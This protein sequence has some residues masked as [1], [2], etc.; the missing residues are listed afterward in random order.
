MTYYNG[1]LGAK[2]GI[3]KRCLTMKRCLYLLILFVIMLLPA[4]SLSRAQGGADGW[5]TIPL[6]LRAGPSTQAA[7]L[8]VLPSGTGIIIEAR[9]DDAAW[10]LAHTEDGAVRGW[11]ARAYLR[12]RPDFALGA[13]PVSAETIGTAAPPSEPLP[14]VTGNANAWPN[15]DLN[16]RQGPG[17]TYRTL[18]QFRPNTPLTV[19]ARNADVSWLLVHT[20]DGAQ[21]GWVSALYLRYQLGFSAAA[22]PV[23][24]E[25][26]TPAAPVVS[27]AQP[28]AV[29]ASGSAAVLMSLPVIPTISGHARQIVQGSGNDPHT[30]IKVG[31]CNSDDWDFLGPLG[32]GNYNLGPY[33]AL[34]PT[35][36]FFRGSLGMD[37]LTTGGGYNVLTVMDPLWAQNPQCQPGESLLRCELRLRRPAVAVMMFGSLDVFSFSAGQFDTTLRQAVATTIENGTIPVLTTFTWCRAD[38][39]GERGLQYNL[40][41]VNVARDYDIPLINFWRAAQSLPNCG[42]LD[43]LHL[44]KPVLTTSADFNGEEQRSG[45]TLRNLLTLQTLDAIRNAALQ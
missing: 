27:A 5:T 15:Y 19:E 29:S 16:L 44:S 3:E 12:F 25:T 24:E 2:P 13:L 17:P 1:V 9:S 42:S 41:V 4:G 39:F 31:D 8:T 32:A 14:A 22:L 23:S 38:E 18:G 40:I 7:V 35:V 33:S 10:L 11:L 43:D 37:N 21:R 28:A 20:A 30:L 36:D 34:Q 45:F 6:N 26:F